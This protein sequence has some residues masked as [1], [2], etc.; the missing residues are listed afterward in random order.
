MISGDRSPQTNYLIRRTVSFKF[1]FLSFYW[2]VLKTTVARF[3]AKSA[4]TLSA[5]LSYYTIFSLPP[6][7][8]IILETTSRF[9]DRQ[10]V[11]QAIFNEIGDLVG[12][13][14]ARQLMATL[15]RLNIFETTWWATAV[16]VIVLVFTATT[17]FVTMQNALNKIF[18]VKAGQLKGYG[19]LKML[20]D[21]ILSFALILSMAFILLVSLIVDALLTSFGDYLKEW[22]GAFSTLMV[23][24]TSFVL[25]IVVISLLFALLFKFL[26]DARLR[27]R[28]T[29]FGAL[30]TAVLFALGQ[31]LI[32]FYIGNSQMASLYDAAGSVLGVML[33]V[34]YTSAIFLFGGTFSYVRA[35]LLNRR[36]MPADYAVRVEQKEVTVEQKEVQ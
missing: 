33:W 21:R 19:I 18:F 35:K 25:P 32:S 14:G 27:W 8:L 3:L 23:I 1:T 12:Q 13:S 9:Y 6:M 20:R 26:P 31:Y 11:Q 34:Y 29:W 28:D 10:E 5:A 4:L 16:G 15:D 36:I 17:V 22:I 7:L 2:K 30:L 24:I